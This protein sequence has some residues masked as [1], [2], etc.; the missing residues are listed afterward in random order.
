MNK[1]LILASSTLLL[2]ASA[3]ADVHLGARASLGYASFWGLEEEYNI[4]E[5][6]GNYSYKGSIK[7]LDGF[8]GFSFSFGLASYFAINEAV[9]ISPNFLISHHSRSNKLKESYEEYYK[10]EL[11]DRDEDESPEVTLSMWNIEIPVLGTFNLGPVFLEAGPIISFNVSA[12]AS[13][14]NP[15]G[16][17]ISVEIDDY[18][19]SVNFG[20]VFGLGKR[21]P[22]GDKALDIDARFTLG[23]TSLTSDDADDWLDHTYEEYA[24]DDRPSDFIIHVGATYWFM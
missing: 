13:V 5:D 23:I 19:S 17:D 3:F 1:A 9:S 8:S 21:I 10:G 18:T 14:D 6:D 24:P 22:L 4:E 11:E 15:K 7:G 16:G 12:E 2:A 20:L